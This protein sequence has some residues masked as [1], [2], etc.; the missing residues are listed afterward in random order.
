MIRCASQHVNFVFAACSLHPLL[1]Q[2]CCRT[3]NDPLACKPSCSEPRDKLNTIQRT[4]PWQPFGW[5]FEH[6]NG[7]KPSSGVTVIGWCADLDLI[8][9]TE[10]VPL[11]DEETCMVL[12]LELCRV[13]PSTLVL[14]TVAISITLTYFVLYTFYLLR[15]LRQLRS[16]TYQAHKI[17]N[18]LV[19][20]MVRA[21]TITSL[22]RESWKLARVL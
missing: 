20:L 18:L 2:Y 5:S 6:V 13:S 3:F 21:P 16:L 11:L 14:I 12:K 9:I 8:I 1:P 10:G 22:L 15:M 17:N 4:P 7:V 19:R